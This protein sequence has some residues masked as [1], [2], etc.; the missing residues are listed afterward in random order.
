MNDL[1]NLSRDP[2]DSAPTEPLFSIIT[3][4]Y[5][6][7]ATIGVT[8]DS[9]RSQTCRRYEHLIIDG[10]STDRTL[11]ICR[12]GHTS[13]ERLTSSP[14]AGI[15]DA[16]NKGLLHSKG[17]YVIFLNAGDTFHS[18]DTLQHIADTIEATGYP[19][20]VYGQTDIVD[21]SRRKVADRHL[22][23]PQKLTL[24]SFAE[25][26]VVCHQAFVALRCITGLFDL[27]YRFSADYDWCI[28][29]LQHSRRNVLLDEPLVDYLAEG[30]TTANRMASLRERFSIMC[31]YYGAIPTVLRHLRFIPRYLRRRRQE[32]AFMSS[33]K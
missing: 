1:K 13:R 22:M 15:Y 3:V 27:R 23:A 30:M 14:D 16:M 4:T 25:G 26:M 7:E 6:A 21:A 12:T 19:G 11:E 2:R 20:I 32:S 17:M 31:Y 18:P 10:A 28:R 33:E 9:V 5:N 29:A 24:R 8:L